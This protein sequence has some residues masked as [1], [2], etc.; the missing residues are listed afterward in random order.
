MNRSQIFF[1]KISEIAEL[2]TVLALSLSLSLSYIQ[3]L[4]IHL[5]SRSVKPGLRPKYPHFRGKS[6]V[7]SFHFFLKDKC[8]GNK[9]DQ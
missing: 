1:K 4:I 8:N 9:T 5:Y 6:P 3:T 2:G 7:F